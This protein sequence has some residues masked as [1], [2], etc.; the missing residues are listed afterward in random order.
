MTNGVEGR[1]T[2]VER[3]SKRREKITAVATQY[4]MERGFENLSVNDLA[5]AVGISV[6]GMYR[7]I[8]TKVDL[9]V[10]VCQNIYGDLRDELGEVAAGP[11]PVA[12]KMRWA[13]ELYL[14]S[15]EDKREQIAMMYREY[16]SLP[17][18]AQREYKQR[19]LAIGS[20]FAD[21]IRSGIQHGSFRS[22]DPTVVAMNIVFLGHLP[23][24]KSW[25]LHDIACSSEQL[26]HQQCEL[27]MSSLGV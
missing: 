25:A 21:L 3:T 23:A 13:I 10:M 12:T 6:G 8:D 20:V 22:V 2:R 19:E 9:L 15:C 27:L 16:R 5:A 26:R 18:D 4:I 11:E 1:L 14:S 17:T 7:Y 24:L